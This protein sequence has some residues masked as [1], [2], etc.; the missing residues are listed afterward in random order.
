MD[1]RDRLEALMK[2]LTKADVARACGLHVN[3]IGQIV[4]R[5]QVPN[6]IDALKL[7]RYLGTTAEE[8]FADEAVTRVKPRVRVVAA[9]PDLAAE[10]ALAR[11]QQKLAADVERNQEHRSTSKGRGRSRKS[12]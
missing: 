10:A 8:L 11:A 3:R 6:V 7:C 4:N 12:L 2:D 1:W 5:G 9:T